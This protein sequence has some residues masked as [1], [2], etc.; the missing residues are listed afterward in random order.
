MTTPIRTLPG[1]VEPLG[2]DGVYEYLRCGT[3]VYRKCGGYYY[4]HSTYR[5][6]L[7]SRAARRIAGALA[8]PS[9]AARRQAAEMLREA[10]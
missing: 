5:T 4:S 2:R 1:P 9:S 10:E 3:E 6:W 8:A 7:A